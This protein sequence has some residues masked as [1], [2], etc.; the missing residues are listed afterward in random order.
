MIA[1]ISQRQQCN[2]T[3]ARSSWYGDLFDAAH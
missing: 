1:R 2:S 3:G